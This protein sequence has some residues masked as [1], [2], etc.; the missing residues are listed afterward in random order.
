MRHTMLLEGPPGTGKTTSLRTALPFLR[1]NLFLLS[2]EPGYDIVMN[3]KIGNLPVPGGNFHY[4]YLPPARPKWGDLKSAAQKIN[5]MDIETLQKQKMG[6]DKAFYD[7]F[8]KMIDALAN[9]KCDC[10]GQSWGP[11]DEWDES[12][13]LC[14]DG[15]TG[16]STMSMDLT[17][18]AKPVKTQPDWGVAMDNLERLVGKCV[19]D[20]RCNFVMIGHIG[21]EKDEISGGV[22]LTTHTLGV[23]LAPK[24]VQ[25]FDEVVLAKRSGG[26]FLWSNDEPNCD[27]KS[28]FLPHGSKLPADFG[29]LLKE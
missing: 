6:I 7:Q 14:T 10:H 29:L 27:L 15:L 3:K 16:I 23:K 17:V 28:R 11:A 8:L 22:H 9:F 13:L 24:L 19:F 4:K 18:G 5:S 1:G 12:N 25:M 2:T 26:E 21:R 20:T